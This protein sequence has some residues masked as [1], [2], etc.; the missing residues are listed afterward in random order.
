MSPIRSRRRPLLALAVV[1]L[2]LAA[3]GFTADEA[4]IAATIRGNL[5]KR[6]PNLPPIDEVTRAPVSGLWELRVGS[7]VIYSDA[8]GSFVIEGEILDTATNVNLT[9]RRI[10]DLTAFDF[11]K[12]PLKDAVVWKQGNGSRKLVVFADPNCGYCKKLERDL[13]G[14][15]D[16]TVFTFLVP[17]LGGDSP[18]KSR[19]IWC[20]KDRGKAWRDWMIA[21]TPPPSARQPCDT[22]ALSRNVLLGEKHAV[23]GTPSLVFENNERMPGIISNEALERKFTLLARRKG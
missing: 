14:V 20:A 15:P 11:A 19:D 6:L 21:N 3:P 23:T 9:R 18:E 13:S 10:E 4:K 17:I 8:Q 1:A 5:A 12:L 7:H 22:A 2:S 16:I